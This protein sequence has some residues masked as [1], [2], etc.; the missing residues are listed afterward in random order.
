MAAA[1]FPRSLARVVQG[2][3]H[4]DRPADQRADAGADDGIDRHTVIGEDAVHAQMGKAAGA[5]S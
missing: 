1:E 3:F 4:R 5:A 2:P